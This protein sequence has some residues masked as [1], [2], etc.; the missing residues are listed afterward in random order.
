MTQGDT[1]RPTSSKAKSES[2]K[3]GHLDFQPQFVLSSSNQ[4]HFIIKRF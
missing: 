4:R 3:R 1:V 2:W